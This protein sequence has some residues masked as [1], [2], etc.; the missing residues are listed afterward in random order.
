MYH[1]FCHT[2]S[3][4]MPR[5]STAITQIPQSPFNTSCW[6]RWCSP[7]SH[8]I[9]AVLSAICPFSFL[10][11]GEVVS[12]FIQQLLSVSI[13]IL[14][15]V[16]PS[17]SSLVAT[18]PNTSSACWSPFC[19]WKWGRLPGLSAA[20]ILICDSWKPLTLGKMPYFSIPST[21]SIIFFSFNAVVTPGGTSYKDGNRWR[22]LYAW[23][24][25]SPSNTSWYVF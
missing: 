19:L 13:D 2:T 21:A 22:Q 7:S 12:F 10:G 14:I 17:P 5:T 6:Q 16:K 8:L 1:S 20:A 9:P 24:T 15:S 3:A 11:C 23:K 4:S 18:Q 25:S